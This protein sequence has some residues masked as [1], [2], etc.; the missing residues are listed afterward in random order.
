LISIQTDYLHKRYE[1]FRDRLKNNINAEPPFKLSY[2]LCT[3]EKKKKVEEE[4][5]EDPD[6]INF[7]NMQLIMRNVPSDYKGK[8]G[9]IQLQ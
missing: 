4:G 6:A 8:P 5:F 7:A 1:Y 9:L 3:E 2:Q